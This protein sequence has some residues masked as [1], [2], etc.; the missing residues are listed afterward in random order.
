MAWATGTAT[1][2]LDLVRRLRDFLTTNSA[3][4]ALG[5]NW[6][7]ISQA[8]EM[9]GLSPSPTAPTLAATNQ[10]M[11]Q[12]PGLAG[13][14]EILVSLQ[15]S[16]TP[17]SSIYNVGIRGQ[18]AYQASVT[19]DAQPG[20]S[21][22]RYMLL[23][24]TSMKYW[25]IANGRCF[26]VIV[27]AGGT[28][29]QMYG[30]FILPEHLPQDWP[31]PLFAGASSY[32]N[33]ANSSVANSHRAYWQSYTSS[34]ASINANSSGVLC[35]PDLNFRPVANV[36]SSPPTSG[37]IQTSWATNSRVTDIRQSLSGLPV[38][39]QGELFT[40]S[41]Q[42]G[43]AFYGRFDGVFYVPAFGRVP[44]EVATIDGVDYLIIPNVVYTGDA[45]YCAYALE[46]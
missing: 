9:G 39:M 27:R 21:S 10:I 25:F 14:D 31:Y 28:Y 16:E 38:L 6:T 40:E 23:L 34:S 18:V 41:A 1:D 4:V 8:G 37:N 11:L 42:L 2:Y 45:N 5:Q 44:E 3:L 46:T 17:G 12:G 7:Q 29:E 33:E 19:A 26:K 13:D 35:L 32:T 36:S 20:A 15:F 24:N 43:S 30:G 22:L